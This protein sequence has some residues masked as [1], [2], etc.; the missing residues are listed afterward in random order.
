[1]TNSGNLIK[2]LGRSLWFDCPCVCPIVYKVYLVIIRQKDVFFLSTP[3]NP[4]PVCNC[5]RKKYNFL[6]LFHYFFSVLLPGAIKTLYQFLSYFMAA[7]KIALLFPIHS[8]LK[9]LGK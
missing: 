9:L 2:R 5:K 4:V 7:P 3:G 6:K 1:M 8:S